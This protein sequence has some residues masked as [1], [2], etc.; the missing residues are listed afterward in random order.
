MVIAPDRPQVDR[1]V[2]RDGF[3]TLT[4]AS[5]LA[6]QIEIDA[7]G[8]TLRLDEIYDKIEFP[9]PESAAEEGGGTFRE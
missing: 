4:D 3:L 2:K 7:I 5:D 8:C 9:A 6:D 1:F